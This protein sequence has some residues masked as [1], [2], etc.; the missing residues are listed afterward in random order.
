M[1]WKLG[2]LH[3]DKESDRLLGMA[4]EKM[5]PGSVTEAEKMARAWMQKNK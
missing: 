4:S 5:D 2:V 3:G 1:W